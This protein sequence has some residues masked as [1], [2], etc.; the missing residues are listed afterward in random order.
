MTLLSDLLDLGLPAV[1]VG[2]QIEFTR[3]L[4]R[5]E[6]MTY[7]GLKFKYLPE[8]DKAQAIAKRPDMAALAGNLDQQISIIPLSAEIKAGYQEAV[9]TLE[10]IASAESM[11]N[12]QAITAIKAEARILL[13]L[14]KLIARQYKADNG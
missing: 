6:K 4:T 11:T 5:P 14:L 13:K 7:L 3:E 10:Q 2:G 8:A 1:E 12:A 9:T